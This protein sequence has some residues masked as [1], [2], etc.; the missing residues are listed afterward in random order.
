MRWIPLAIVLLGNTDTVSN[1]RTWTY[2]S[3]DGGTLRALVER[4]EPGDTIVVEGV[5]SEGL[6]HIDKSLVMLGGKGAV[7]DGG[8]EGHVL[9]ISADDVTIRGLTIRGTRFS[10][11]DDLAG[12]FV[13]ECRRTV[14][15]DN[16][17][18]K[19]FFAIYLSGSKGAVVEGNTVLGE[20]GQEERMAN[21]IHLWKC[22]DATIRNNRVEHHRDG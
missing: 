21:G 14:I 13:Q 15:A 9:A 2:R 11:M 4:V 12:I 5:V 10:G 7:I 6:V 8:G 1:A 22:S 17:L 19:C 18:D 16:F 20:P 3:A